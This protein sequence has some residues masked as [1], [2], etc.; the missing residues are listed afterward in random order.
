MLRRILPINSVSFSTFI[1][2]YR[3]MTR[4]VEKKILSIEQSEGVGAKVRRSIGT[5]QVCDRLVF[6]FIVL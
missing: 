3:T 6:G 4:Y 5:S 2:S 1:N